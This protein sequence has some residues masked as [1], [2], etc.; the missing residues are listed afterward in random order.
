[1]QTLLKAV[2]LSL[3]GCPLQMKIYKWHVDAIETV[4]QK[5]GSTVLTFSN[6]P[7]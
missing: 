4:D 6:I 3:A 1:M 7:S 2:R 5:P